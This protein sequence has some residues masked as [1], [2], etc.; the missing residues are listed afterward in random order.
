MGK[1]LGFIQ[2]D[3][4]KEHLKLYHQTLNRLEKTRMV[5][6][7]AAVRFGKA[8]GISVRVMLIVQCAQAASRLIRLRS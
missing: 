2:A 5:E 8:R 7:K 6:P 3:N 1:I 4:Q